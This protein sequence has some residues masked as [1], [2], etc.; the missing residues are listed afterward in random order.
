MQAGFTT[1]NPSYL[2]AQL[3]TQ[4][5]EFL[6]SL[7]G[8]MAVRKVLPFS[9]MQSYL[10]MTYQC[11]QS[12]LVF[13]YLAA[14]DTHACLLSTKLPESYLAK[15]YSHQQPHTKAT[16]TCIGCLQYHQC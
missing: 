15:L 1:C 7:G 16:L 12:M 5:S 8:F 14:P 2:S 9:S 13:E 11:L 4:D 6:K 3:V 10:A